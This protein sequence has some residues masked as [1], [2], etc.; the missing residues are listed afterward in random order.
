MLNLQVYLLITLQ[1]ALIRAIRIQLLTMR[2]MQIVQKLD[3][4]TKEKLI[5]TLRIWEKKEA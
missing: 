3:A 5:S 1:A 4:D 2:I